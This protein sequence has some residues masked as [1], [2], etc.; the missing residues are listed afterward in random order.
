MPCDAY[1]HSKLF[2][3][4]HIYWLVASSA[5]S[6]YLKQCWFIVYWN[7][8]NTFQWNWNQI[9]AILIQENQ[10]DIVICKVAEILSRP[11]CVKLNTL[12]PRDT[13]A[14]V[15]FAIIGSDTGLLPVQHQAIICTYAGLSSHL[16]ILGVT[17]VFVPLCTLLP[18]P[19]AHFVYAITFRRLFRFLSFLA[20]LM[21]LT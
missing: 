1:M 10:F 17:Y 21:D 12:R 11:Q 4:L 18:P 6:H 14:S 9:T 16:G 15:S 8:R 7:I 2:F 19:A 13:Y 3:L 5:P 20:Q